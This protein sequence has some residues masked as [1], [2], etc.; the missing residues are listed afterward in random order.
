VA[1]T[2]RLVFADTIFKPLILGP[3]ALQLFNFSRNLALAASTMFLLWAVLQ[4]IWPELTP[5]SFLSSPGVLVHRALTQAIWTIAAVPAARILIALNNAIVAAFDTAAVP[6]A[7]TSETALG[8][9]TDPVAVTV[10]LFAILILIMLLGIYY[11]VRSL[12]IVVLVA[13]IPWF[14]LIW[15]AHVGDTTLK[16]LVKELAVAIFVQSVHAGVFYVF[17]RVLIDQSGSIA[18]QLMAVALLWYMLKIPQQLRRIVGAVGP[19]GLV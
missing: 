13:L 5:G 17:M 6:T 1:S 10:V 14:A 11:T 9:L 15:M 2:T 19:G 18:G 12:E 4:M 16:K 8:M 7:F 3:A